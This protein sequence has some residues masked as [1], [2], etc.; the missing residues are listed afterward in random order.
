[1]ISI[2]EEI[3]SPATASRRISSPP[4]GLPELLEARGQFVRLGV[5]DRELLLDPDRE[6][7]GGGEDLGRAV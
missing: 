5:E 2:S 7:R 1:M 4:G 6:V 3:S